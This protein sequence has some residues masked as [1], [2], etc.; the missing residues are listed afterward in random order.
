[1]LE[2]LTDRPEC[3]KDANMISFGGEVILSVMTDVSIASPPG[4][5]DDPVD[6][7]YAA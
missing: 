6:E 7:S 3:D 2:L 1:M 5:F 4:I